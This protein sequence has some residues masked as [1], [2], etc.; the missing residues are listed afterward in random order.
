[1]PSYVITRDWDIHFA[2][3]YLLRLLGMTSTQYEAIPP[4]LR[5]IIQVIF[6]SSLPTYDRLSINP[7]NW[8]YIAKRNVYGFKSTNLFCEFEDWYKERVDRWCWLLTKG[9]P[10]FKRYWSEVHL[11]SQ[12]AHAADHVPF[13]FYTTDMQVVTGEIV[14]FRSLLTSLGNYDYPQVV[15]YIPADRASCRTFERLGIPIPAG[16]EPTDD[17]HQA[18]I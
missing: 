10:L 14:R 1:M 15:S 18:F 13:P 7:S 17:A 4:K 12:I 16:W 2:N 6:D 5:N 8:R 9:E 11:D 3:E